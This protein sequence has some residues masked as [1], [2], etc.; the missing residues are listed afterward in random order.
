MTEKVIVLDRGNVEFL[1]PRDWR[2]A[3]GPQG[4]ITLS[5][6]TESCRLD[7][8][9]TRHAEDMSAA[10]VEELLR[11]LLARL[12]EAESDTPIHCLDEPSRRVAWCDY[13]Y[14]SNDK[15]TGL[16]KIARGRWLVGSNAV[17]RVLMAFYYWDDDVA[18]AVPAWERIVETLQFGDGT[19]LASPKEHW[20]MRRRH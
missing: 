8:S 9:Y 12:R 20:S 16:P 17:F 6:P 11:Q 18:W 10:A 2:V 19:Q 5:D 14:V 3:R 1:Y 4:A 15:R 7:V 13:E